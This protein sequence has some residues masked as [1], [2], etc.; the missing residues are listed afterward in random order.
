MDR[1]QDQPRAAPPSTLLLRY[2]QSV[3]EAKAFGKAAQ[4]NMPQVPCT[5]RSRAHVFHSTTWRKD[6]ARI[7]LSIVS[8]R[9]LWLIR[10][11]IRHEP[12]AG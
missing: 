5:G 11:E 4:K 1:A 10:P 6:A 2:M 7:S 9:P 3:W 8:K 12:G